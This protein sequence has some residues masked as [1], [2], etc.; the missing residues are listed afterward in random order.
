MWKGKI[1]EIMPP[2]RLPVRKSVGYFLDQLYICEE[3]A[4]CEWY[5]LLGDGPGLYETAG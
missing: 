2:F 3:R 4:H 1:I 5:H